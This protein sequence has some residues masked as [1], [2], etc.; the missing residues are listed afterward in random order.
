MCVWLCNVLKEIRSKTDT[1]FLIYRFILI[2]RMLLYTDMLTCLYSATAC[3]HTVNSLPWI[4]RFHWVCRF[5]PPGCSVVMLMY[6]TSHC[7]LWLWK[8]FQLKREIVLMLCRNFTAAWKITG[9]KRT[10]CFWHRHKWHQTYTEHKHFWWHDY[11]QLLWHPNDIETWFFLALSGKQ[12]VKEDKYA[13]KVSLNTSAVLIISPYKN[14]LQVWRGKLFIWKSK[15][16]ETYKKLKQMSGQFVRY[17]QHNWVF[18]TSTKSVCKGFTY[19]IHLV[20]N[21]MNTSL[22]SGEKVRLYQSIPD[23]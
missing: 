16:G 6:S 1:H 12:L 22:D 13:F 23:R 7:F 15:Q 21:S 3:P 20:Q 18:H 4:F 10:S 11:F 14:Y 9:R 5:S 8:N 2:V 19:L 17:E